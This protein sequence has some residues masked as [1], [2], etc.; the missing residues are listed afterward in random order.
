MV[1]CSERTRERLARDLEATGQGEL[2]VSAEEDDSDDG[3]EIVGEVSGGSELDDA[4][5]SEF[6]DEDRDISPADDGVPIDL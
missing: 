1:A 5:D 4:N 2:D 6:K 3:V